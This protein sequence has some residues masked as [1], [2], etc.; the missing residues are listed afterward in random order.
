MPTTETQKT[1][2]MLDRIKHAPAV[3][4]KVRALVD[5][6]D[7]MRSIVDTDGAEP[8]R[9]TRTQQTFALA[10]VG[11][12]LNAIGRHDL[13]R[14]FQEI[15]STLSDLDRGIV[16]PS[17][18]RSGARAAG[19][20]QPQ[21]SNVWRARAYVAAAVDTM[22]RAELPMKIIKAK[23]DTYAVLHSLLDKKRK[24]HTTLGDAAEGW[25]E[26]FNNGEVNNFE[27]VG[28]YANY[29]G[30]AAAVSDPEKIKLAEIFLQ[31]AI[32]RMP[33]INRDSR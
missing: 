13:A 3:S 27:A 16:R 11:Q 15:A 30:M 24:D 9:L 6:I 7:W 2:E 19:G 26:Q 10:A 33:S 14:E 8:G 17:V 32:S 12:F 21:P 23:I 4:G 18:E 20:P 1:T 5:A 25:R 29:Q 28:T 22:M 31:M